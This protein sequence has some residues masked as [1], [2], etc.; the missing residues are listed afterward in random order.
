[1]SEVNFDV[2]LEEEMGD[3]YYCIDTPNPGVRMVSEKAKSADGEDDVHLRLMCQECDDKIDEW[4][5][6]D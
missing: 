4:I 6:E 2:I 5:D 1:M 3:C